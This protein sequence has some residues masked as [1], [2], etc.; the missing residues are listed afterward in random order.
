MKLSKEDQKGALLGISQM[1]N[2]DKVQAQEATLQVGQRV[3]GF[4]QYFAQA[5]GKTTAEMSKLMEL[6]KTNT[7]MVVNAGNFLGQKADEM[8]TL[9]E[10]LA[11]GVSAQTRWENAMKWMSH[12]FTKEADPALAQFFDSV[13]EFVKILTPAIKL[14]AKLFSAIVVVLSG[15]FMLLKGIASLESSG[16]LIIGVIGLITLALVRWKRIM[17]ALD[18]VASFADLREVMKTTRL[19]ALGLIVVFA[20]LA[21]AAYD[22]AQANRGADNWVGDWRQFIYL[23]IADLHIAMNEISIFWDDMSFRAEL[24]YNAIKNLNFPELWKVI[25]GRSKSDYSV[26]QNNLPS[27]AK[28]ILNSILAAPMLPTMG[29]LNLV[30]RDGTAMGDANIPSVLPSSGE[31][32]LSASLALTINQ[33]GSNGQIIAQDTRDMMIDF[34]NTSMAFNM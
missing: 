19:A 25:S 28:A 5:N 2:K 16:L 26:D 23:L 30:F 34:T 1:F 13:A 32:S 7:D 20:L 21:K 6:G 24:A 18:L 15:I 31:K 11:T 4:V 10:A 14:L 22:I 17:K 9:A 33:M 3:A 8:G 29:L 12:A 27:N